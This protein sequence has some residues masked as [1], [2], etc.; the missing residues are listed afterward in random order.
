MT[1]Y[2]GGVKLG[3]RGLIDAYRHVAEETISKATLKE[4]IL[5]DYWEI[6]TDYAH[7]DKIKHA[8]DELSAEI[9][10]ADY[11]EEVTIY[12]NAIVNGALREF[13]QNKQDA[14]LL[15]FRLLKTE[16]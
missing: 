15:K 9:L 1:R 11:Q 13:L 8:I 7:A 3:I 4:M 5:K 10:S 16:L 12:A 6:I 14:G 2:F